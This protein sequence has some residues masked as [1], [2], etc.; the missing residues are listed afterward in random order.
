MFDD[1]MP[2]FG[3][4]DTFWQEPDFFLADL[5]S[6]FVN[7]GGMELGVTLFVRG[8]VITGTLVSER[9]Y[10]QAMS[11]MFAEQ[12]RKSLVKPTKEDLKI[13]R[14]VFDFTRMAEDED[15]EDFRRRAAQ[16]KNA[17]KKGDSRFYDPEGMDEE[18]S[19]VPIRHLHVREPV[20][21]QPQPA[22]SFS[23]SQ[24]P[25]LRLRLTQID[26]W[27]I[28]KVNVEDDDDDLLDDFPPPP[29]QIRH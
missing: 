1:I 4:E 27:M 2:D 16:A 10:L 15:P 21:L 22:V 5:V 6:G 28:G 14:E 9:E 18:E 20:I 26:G 12:A 8:V 23:H 17:N 11:D 7:K 3:G 13:T 25:I 29:S 19:A 24:V